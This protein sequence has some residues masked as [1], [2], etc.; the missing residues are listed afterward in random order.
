MDRLTFLKS[1]LG[2]A[3]L[4]TIPPL[5]LLPK[6]EQ[7]RLAWSKDCHLI[8]IYDTYIRGFQFHQGPELITRIKPEDTLDLVREYTNEHDDNAVAVYWEGHK[9][10]Y[11]P[12]FE[13]ISLAGMIDHGLLLKCHVVYTQPKAKPWEQCFIAIDL[14]V[15][16]HPSFDAY[17]THY[18]DRPDA[19]Y[20]RRPENG[21]VVEPEPE[22]KAQGP[23]EPKKEKLLKNREAIQLLSLQRFRLFLNAVVEEGDPPICV[24]LFLKEAEA[25]GF[26]LR[27]QRIGK[28]GETLSLRVLGPD[29]FR[30][31]FSWA[32]GHTGDGGEWDVIFNPV[33]TVQHLEVREHWIA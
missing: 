19:G 30:I 22:P 18:M 16:R 13:N 25:E 32:M 7:D 26:M 12:M 4:L 9:L 11:L 3:A 27:S 21:G 1:M 31:R 20:K 24:K 14:L 29:H 10:G 15:P 28:D 17:I 2:N 23:A 33:G 8:F 6:E 5:E